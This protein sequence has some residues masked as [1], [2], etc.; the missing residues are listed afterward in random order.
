MQGMSLHFRTIF[1]ESFT[2]SRNKTTSKQVYT[3]SAEN[4]HA[5]RTAAENPILDS[6]GGLPNFG[7]VSPFSWR[8]PS[9][10]Q[11]LSNLD[12]PPQSAPENGE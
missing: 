4:F 3:L 1:V 12:T 8:S 7:E 9:M 2:T 5:N 6:Q 11:G 10:W